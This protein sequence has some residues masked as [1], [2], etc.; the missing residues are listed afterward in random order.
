VF[1]INACNLTEAPRCVNHI[2]TQ[3]LRP[4]AAPAQRV[5]AAPVRGAEA[6]RLRPSALAR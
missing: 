2:A 4:S 6:T 5:G 1:S 3:R